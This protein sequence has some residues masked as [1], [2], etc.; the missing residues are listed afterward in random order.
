MDRLKILADSIRDIPDFPQKGVIFK[1]ITTLLSNPTTFRLAIDTMYQQYQ[2]EKI[3]AVV[4][5][6]ARGFILGAVLAY[7]LNSGLVLVRKKG[8][9]P[10]KTYQVTYSLE[11]GKDTLEVHQDAIKQG[12]SVIIVDDVLATGGTISAVCKLLEKL[13]AKI[14]GIGFLIE[15]TF[16]NG[17]KKLP[18]HNILSLL[19]Y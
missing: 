16:L 2:G 6:E 14:V 7:K 10:Y 11:Y 15:L 12:D 3:A 13:N 9:L 5:V 17:R 19:K 18:D 4:C 1:D 8:K